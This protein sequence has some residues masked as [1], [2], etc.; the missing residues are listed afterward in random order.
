MRLLFHITLVIFFLSLCSSLSKHS[1]YKQQLEH[2]PTRHNFFL[3]YKKSVC[4]A[5]TSIA[6]FTGNRNQHRRLAILYVS[7]QCEPF[8]QRSHHCSSTRTTRCGSALQCKAN[9]IFTLDREA[10]NSKKTKR[11]KSL[12]HVQ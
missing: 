2:G 4:V 11:L 7:I 1:P 8:A 12:T 9:R 3:T 5:L 10:G 6:R